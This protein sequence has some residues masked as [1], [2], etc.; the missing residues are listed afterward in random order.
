[1]DA[2]V[3]HARS[4]LLLSKTK[5]QQVNIAMQNLSKLRPITQGTQVEQGEM[6]GIGNVPG[7][8]EITAIQPQNIISIPDD[9]ADLAVRAMIQSQNV[10][11]QPS[12]QN[13]LPGVGE[14]YVDILPQGVISTGLIRIPTTATT[15]AST[16]STSTAGTST[17]STSVAGT[18]ATGISGIVSNKQ[19][20]CELDLI[21]VTKSDIPD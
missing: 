10:E 17:A 21:V 14:G 16:T 8:I 12:A 1:M 5:M 11:G 13:I 20:K 2:D 9:E 4:R 6:S 15:S 7:N 18:S 19:Q 3:E